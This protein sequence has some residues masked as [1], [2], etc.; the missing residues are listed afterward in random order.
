MILQLNE[1]RKR[2]SKRKRIHRKAVCRYLHDVAAYLP[3]GR[4]QKR[5]ILT[6]LR[7]LINSHPQLFS[8]PISLEAAFGS[9]EEIAQT[10]IGEN[11][12]SL[13]RRSKKQQRMI[14]SAV[15]FLLLIT[16]TVTGI[17]FLSPAVHYTETVTVFENETESVYV[18]S[19]Y[20][21]PQVAQP[22]TGSKTVTCYDHR[23]TKLWTA[24][25][26]GT[27]GYVYGNIG[28]ALTVD[29][30]LTVY[31]KNGLIVTHKDTLLPDTAVS[32]VAAEYNGFT[33]Q[34]KIMLSCDRF[35]NLS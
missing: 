16:L 32:T 9:P 30:T 8:T 10:Y 11:S 31:D 35:G 7:T 1:E 5:T 33:L 2:L 17:L 24:T 13:L 12:V 18:T 20:A 4:Q 26:Y 23:G 19:P 22:R 21:P 27:F 15:L 34:K 29:C 6:E 28:Q 25:V 3:C 14:L